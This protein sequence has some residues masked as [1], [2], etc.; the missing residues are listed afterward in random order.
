M[1]HVCINVSLKGF[2]YSVAGPGEYLT[3]EVTGVCGK[4]LLVACRIKNGPNV[5]LVA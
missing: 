2:Y 3:R 1:P 4:S 5:Y